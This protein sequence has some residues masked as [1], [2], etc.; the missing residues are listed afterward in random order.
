MLFHYRPAKAT[1]VDLPEGSDAH[2]FFQQEI[3]FHQ[4]ISALS[5]FPELLRRLGL[6]FDLQVPADALP[7]TSSGSSKVRVIPNWISS[8]PT[9][10]PVKQNQKNGLQTAVRG[11]S[12]T[13]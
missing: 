2:T 7:M 9:R 1:P 6:V 12:M 4:M 13:M 3:D 5:D 11:L 8:F 10:D